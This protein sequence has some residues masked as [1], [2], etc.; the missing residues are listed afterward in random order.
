LLCDKFINFFSELQLC[1]VKSIAP[2]QRRNAKFQSQYDTGIP[3]GINPEKH[4]N[5]IPTSE[6]R[7]FSKAHRPQRPLIFNIGDLKLRDLTKLWFYKLIA[8]K[9]NFKKSIMTSF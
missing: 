7:N 9:S 5:V 6:R 8:T 1:D 4:K 2:K 3:Q